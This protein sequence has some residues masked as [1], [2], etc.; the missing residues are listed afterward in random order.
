MADSR[1]PGSNTL[2]AIDDLSNARARGASEAEIRDLQ[3]AFEEARS[4]E[5]DPAPKDPT[6]ILIQ[7]LAAERRGAPAAVQDSLKAKLAAI[8]PSAEGEGLDPH[9]LARE[10][11]LL[12]SSGASAESIAPLQAQEISATER[13][14]RQESGVSDPVVLFQIWQESPRD[15]SNVLLQRRRQRFEQARTEPVDATFL[16]KVMLDAQKKGRAAAS[17]YRRRYLVSLAREVAAAEAPGRS[18][19]KKLALDALVRR[20]APAALVEAMKRGIAKQQAAEQ[21]ILSGLGIRSPAPPTTVAPARRGFARA[22]DSATKA[23]SRPSILRDLVTAAVIT[24]PAW[25]TLLLLRR[26]ST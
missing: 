1:T 15:G 13:V 11:R 10:I 4:I 19:T 14:I 6:R 8:V 17:T 16:Q 22:S 25:I 18:T 12:Q 5:D 20:R 21:G 23:P 2:A 26:A 24:S 9:A 3:A 7:I